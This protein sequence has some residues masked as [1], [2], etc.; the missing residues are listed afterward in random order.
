MGTR[1]QS[2][3]PKDSEPGN[4]SSA[5]WDK[6]GQRKPGKSR[7]ESTKTKR[8]TKADFPISG[9]FAP[10][11]RRG[12]RPLCS[13]PPSRFKLND[14]FSHLP[15]ELIELIFDDLDVENL[16][17]CALVS[18]SLVAPSQQLIFR[19]LVI[20][21]ALR[22]PLGPSVPDPCTL[23]VVDFFDA[24]TKQH[25]AWRASTGGRE[26][27]EQGQAGK[28]GMPYRHVLG[29]VGGETVVTGLV[30][31]DQEM[32]FNLLARGTK[33]VAKLACDLGHHW[34]IQHLHTQVFGHF[35][36]L[37]FTRSIVDRANIEVS[38]E[39]SKVS[40]L[41]ICAPPLAGQPLSC[42]LMFW[43]A[44][45][46]RRLPESETWNLNRSQEFGFPTQIFQSWWLRPYLRWH[47]IFH[48]IPIESGIFRSAEQSARIYSLWQH[49]LDSLGFAPRLSSKC[50]W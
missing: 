42:I 34:I 43:G 48:A 9:P 24:G 8:R 4:F 17:A 18:S 46:M 39:L 3:W 11:S 1:E 19:S 36:S 23:F 7:N 35:G 20:Q 16:R 45:K 32:H 28:T 25:L 15:Q 38:A 2:L 5:I 50:D 6:C 40:V 26:K 21:M 27:Q 49:G 30:I 41:F 37:N 33:N 31:H 44:Q 12:C 22:A 13:Q 14:M 10:S 47:L 29:C